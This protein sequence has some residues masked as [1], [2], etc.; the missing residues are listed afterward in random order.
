M[1]RCGCGCASVEL[2]IDGHQVASGSMHILSDYQWTDKQGHVFGVYVFARG[3][4]LAGLDVWSID[5]QAP[6]SSLPAVQW[7]MPLNR[8]ALH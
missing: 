7:L 4:S 1:G 6:A 5:G 2:A 8:G 3:D